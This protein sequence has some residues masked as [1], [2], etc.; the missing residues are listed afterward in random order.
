MEE[1]IGD[2]SVGGNHV[3]IEMTHAGDEKYFWENIIQSFSRVLFVV[4][5]KDDDRDNDNVI[6][7]SSGVISFIDFTIRSLLHI[8]VNV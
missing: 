5:E 6:L 1:Q 7:T 2:E 4:L 8:T 3:N